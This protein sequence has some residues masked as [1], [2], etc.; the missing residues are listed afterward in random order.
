MA[1]IEWLPDAKADLQRLYDFI[2]PHNPQAA[3][4][5]VEAIILGVDQLAEFPEAGRPWEPDLDFRELIVPFGARAYVVRYRLFGERVIIVR[6]WHGLE[7]RN[8]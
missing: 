4:R 1:P 2:R 6:V 5:A 3:A 8:R 7:D